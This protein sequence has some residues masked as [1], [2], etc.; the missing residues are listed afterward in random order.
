MGAGAMVAVLLALLLLFRTGEPPRP[1]DPAPVAIGGSPPSHSAL[2][3]LR[4]GEDPPPPPEPE[5]VETDVHSAEAPS[6]D[7]ADVLPAFQFRD[8]L[9]GR[10][11][12]GLAVRFKGSGAAEMERV[13]DGN[14]ILRPDGDT[15][16]EFT[17][18]GGR[19]FRCNDGRGAPAADPVV[20]WLH[21]QRRY[22]PRVV[23]R[24]LAPGEPEPDVTFKVF[25]D[26]E[27]GATAPMGAFHRM[28]ALRSPV[29]MTA[30]GD[31]RYEG[32]IPVLHDYLLSA[33]TDH[34]RA[35]FVEVAPP[36][37]DSPVE[38]EFV[39][40]RKRRIV[41]RVRD[42]AGLP[43]A[44]EAVRCIQLQR[45]AYDRA[46]SRTARLFALQSLGGGAGMSGSEAR[47]E[48]IEQ[49]EWSAVTDEAGGF[50][51]EI[52]DEGEI[53]L[54]FWNDGFERR[55]VPLAGASQATSGGDGDGLIEVVRVPSD[56]SAKLALKY[57]GAAL[58]PGRRIH[59]TD[60]S[61]YPLEFSRSFLITGEGGISAESLVTGVTYGIMDGSDSA[62]FEYTGQDS[63]EIST[64]QSLQDWL[65][66]R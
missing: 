23:F 14:G 30:I 63:V 19:W 35:G 66:E 64:L 42:G 9:D 56:T 12:A 16:T 32:T 31:G 47:N 3:P 28:T 33:S 5:P 50:E 22:L 34:W 55:L 17:L 45:S 29:A 18:P 6:E 43:V 52:P 13:T 26:N 57:K 11:V 51:F 36:D 46:H 49:R 41:G 60:L 8:I 39:L 20:I 59:L 61:L 25:A 2:D 48:W 44:K 58:E 62:V 21:R 10:P 27:R 54:L 38:V 7:S 37:P 53:H 40:Q 4:T 15:G 65:K 1:V 24:G